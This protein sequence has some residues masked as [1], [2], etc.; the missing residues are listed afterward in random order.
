MQNNVIIECVRG[1]LTKRRLISNSF[2]AIL[3][4]KVQEINMLKNELEKYKM[5]EKIATSILESPYCYSSST[6]QQRF[7]NRKKHTVTNQFQQLNT[8]GGALGINFEAT[9]CVQHNN[10]ILD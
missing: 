3:Q 4:E 5:G 1:E 10:N 9:D 8:S 2:E 6:A 7:N